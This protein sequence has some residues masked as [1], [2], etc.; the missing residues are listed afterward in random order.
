MERATKSRAN[1]RSPQAIDVVAGR[2]LRLLRGIRGYSQEEL[3]DEVGISFQQI[4]K[5]EN[6]KN[7]M[8]LSRAREFAMILRVGI[9]ELFR[10]AEF[11][12]ANALLDT[13]KLGDWLAL[14]GRAQDAGLLSEI[15]SLAAQAL[16][17]CE[18]TLRAEAQC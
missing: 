16:R 3:G 10:D 18:T 8:S 7:R 17:I 14:Y 2:N 9:D 12:A 5:Y 13:S 4:Q 11:I 15:C 6:G 1:Q